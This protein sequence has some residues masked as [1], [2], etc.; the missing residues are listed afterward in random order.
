MNDRYH[1]QQGHQINW[2]QV[3]KYLDLSKRG[4]DVQTVET[5][6][7]GEQIRSQPSVSF[8][9][10]GRAWGSSLMMDSVTIDKATL[11]TLSQS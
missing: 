3:F 11:E 9:R 5:T 10:S 2:L 7:S 8:S 1:P 6:S 4:L